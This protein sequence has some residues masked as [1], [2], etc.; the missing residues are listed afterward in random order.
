M[1]DKAHSH[2]VVHKQILHDEIG[3]ERLQWCSE[4][5]WG[6]LGQVT[7]GGERSDEL[8]QVSRVQTFVQ[9]LEKH[10]RFN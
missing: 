10:T 3:D 5:F 6:Q 9:R 8:L 2:P 7:Q 4:L 1:D